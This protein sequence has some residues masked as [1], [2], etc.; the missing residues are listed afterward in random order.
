MAKFCSNCGNKV[1]EK[2][3]VCSNCGKVLKEIEENVE[4]IEPVTN[5]YNSPEQKPAN[6]LAI[7]GF[8]VSLVSLVCC[9]GI[10]GII[11]L[12]LSVV[13][14]SKAKELNGSGQGLAVAGI[15]LGIISMLYFIIILF[16]YFAAF[17]NYV[18]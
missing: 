18:A 1:S 11:G 2:D 13:G 15:V 9:G 7:A 17:L 3:N 8:V 10:F 5:Q 6:G 4:V 16:V 14:S 12:I